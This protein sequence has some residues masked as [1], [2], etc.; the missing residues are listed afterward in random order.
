MTAGL[1]LVAGSVGCATTAFA[2]DLELQIGPDGPRIH[3]REY[4]RDYGRDDGDRYDHR[5]HHDF[6]GSSEAE[7][8]AREYGFHRPR[9][10]YRN[11]RVVVVEGFRRGGPDRIRFANERDCP[12]IR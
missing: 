12:R 6:C 2:Q 4:G 11:D 7:D 10:V 1:L 3:Q 8:A 9:V 5:R